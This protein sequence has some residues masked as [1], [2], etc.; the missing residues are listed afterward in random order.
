MIKW[1][2]NWESTESCEGLT[3]NRCGINEN[4]SGRVKKIKYNRKRDIQVVFNRFREDFLSR[5]YPNNRLAEHFFRQDLEKLSANFSGLFLFQYS[6]FSRYWFHRHIYRSVELSGESD[7]TFGS[8]RQASVNGAL[9]YLPN[10]QAHI[11]SM[12]IAWIAK[13][14]RVP[15]PMFIAW[16]TLAKRRSSYLMPLVNSCLLDRQIMD[17]RFKALDAFRNTR[18]YRAGYAALFTGY[19]RHMLSGGIDTLIY[20]EGGRTYS[21]QTGEARIKRVFKAVQQVQQEATG[22]YDISVVPISLSFSLVPEAEQ[23]IR[24][25]HTRSFLPPSSLFHDMQYGD[26]Q[27]AAFKPVYDVKTDYPFIR[28]FAR[29]RLPVFCVLGDP[30]SLKNNKDISLQQC[31]DV[32]ISNLK[33]LPQHFVARLLLSDPIAMADRWKNDGIKGLIKPARLLCGNL[34]APHLDEAYF[35]DDGLADIIAIGMEF[36]QYSDAITRKGNIQNSLVLEY[37]SNKCITGG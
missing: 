32:V 8:I 30:I 26:D 24:A 25:Y 33:I 18:N 13:V 36:F 37:Y 9:F 7:Q 34:S 28:A 31:F 20:P 17:N 1:S 5:F 29:K 3:E 35:S 11:D 19:L 10:H 12:I 14:L 4:M 16:N 15:Q 22:H 6:L 2:R 27:Y 23:L 21:G